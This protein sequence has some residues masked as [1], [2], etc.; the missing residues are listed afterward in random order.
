MLLTQKLVQISAWHGEMSLSL[1]TGQ[2]RR[3][4]GPELYF[5]QLLLAAAQGTAP[6][7][8][9]TSNPL[10]SLHLTLHIYKVELKL[11]TAPR[12]E[13]RHLALPVFQKHPDMKGA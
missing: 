1:R 2:P 3:W 7:L 5:W 6:Q 8:C 11:I 13:L 4:Q 10:T 9:C 12:M